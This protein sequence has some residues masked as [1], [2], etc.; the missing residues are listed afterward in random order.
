MLA[1]ASK[2]WWVLLLR[3]LLAIGF[4][5][6]ALVWPSLT[7]LALVVVFGVYSLLDGI[8]D[9]SMGI[10]GRQLPGSSRWVLVL[11][12]LFGIA[13]GIIAFL[14]PE[15]TAVALLWIIATWAIITGIFE[16]VAAI[17]LRAEID[18]EWLWI[19]TGILSV[20]L[21]VILIF[22]PAAGALA[23]VTTIAIFSI[24]WGVV[25]VTLSFKLKGLKATAQPTPRVA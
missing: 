16:M 5:I 3:G 9:I 23:L 6:G 14:W 1:V 10:G 20:I 21:G 12:G 15:I 22:Q 25:L 11:M 18:N 24:A 13:A 19:L 17:R 7:I 4:G 2:Y 8:L